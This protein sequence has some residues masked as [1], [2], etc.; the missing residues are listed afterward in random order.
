VA[1]LAETTKALVGGE[2]SLAQAGVIARTEAACPGTEAE[3]LAV[4]RSS[5]LGELKDRART[6]RLEAIPAD[7]LLARQRRA[8]SL[9]HWRDELG[10][11]RLA[12]AL[13]PDV[14]VGL[15]N[16]L[17]AE[18][19]RIRRAAR[20]ERS[21]DA[22][23]ADEPREAHAADALVKLLSGQGTG[24]AQRADVVFVCDLAA[25]RR[26]HTHHGEACHIVGGGPVPVGVV[27]DMID[28][29]FIKA[30]L[31]DG[32]RIDTVAH[33][34]RHIGAEL[35]TALE[36]GPV[37]AFDGVTCAEQGCGRRHGLEWDHVDPVAN[38]GPT[39]Y[40]NLQPRCRPHHWEKT[41][42]DREAGL[43]GGARRR[44]DPP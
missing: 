28:D 30:V 31:H 4:A 22:D 21:D 44:G 34:G 23:E 36:L 38:G 2:L 15:M 7:E 25:Y 11:V 41:E 35:R 29:A 12:G 16:R 8:R 3:L 27:R 10:M 5:G 13:P 17:D 24:A 14:G 19:D 43:L 32:V 40:E 18:A 26:G 9:R 6:R 37:P 1:K 20:A 42:R 33:Y 39:S